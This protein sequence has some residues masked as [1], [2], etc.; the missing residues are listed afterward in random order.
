MKRGDLYQMTKIFCNKLIVFISLLLLIS[1]AKKPE[2]PLHPA[3]G[4]TAEKNKF[5]VNFTCAITNEN[6]YKAFINTSGVISIKNNG[7][8][9]LLEIPFEAPVI[10]PFATINI[11]EGIEL[12][13]SA[14]TPLLALLDIDKER[15]KSGENIGKKYID[16]KNIEYK[17]LNLETKDI[18]ELLRGKI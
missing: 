8:S 11:D 13:E 12:S 16:E 17:E 6:E 1:C 15:I 10:L 7:G 2:S 3:V 4:V 18:I 5:L 14:I 9:I